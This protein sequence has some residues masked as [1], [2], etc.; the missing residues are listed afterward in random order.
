MASYWIVVPRDNPELFELLSV[1]FRGRAG[2]NVIVDRRGPTSTSPDGERRASNAQLSHD[3]F[4]IAERA[5]RTAEE[6]DQAGSDTKH[7]HTGPQVPVRRRRPRRSGYRIENGPG[8]ARTIR[9][10]S[11]DRLFTL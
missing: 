11:Y 3:E 5:D 2:F 4:I 1:A 7:R 10:A 6:A 8:H 9:V